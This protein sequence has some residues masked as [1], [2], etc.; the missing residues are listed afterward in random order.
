[1]SFV[2]DVTVKFPIK[3]KHTF[4]FEIKKY[5]EIHVAYTNGNFI[6]T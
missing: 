3:K 1:M 6:P 5:L 2:T 4:S